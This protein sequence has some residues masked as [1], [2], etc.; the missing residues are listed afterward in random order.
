MPAEFE[1]VIDNLIK[2][3]PQAN[4]FIDDILIASKGTKIEHIVGGKDIEK[5]GCLQYRVKIAKMRICKN[6]VRMARISNWGKWYHAI[7]K[8]NTS[9]R[10]LA[11]PQNL[12][13][14]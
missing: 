6:G 13:N 14:S 9:K 12:E 7:S 3:F 4:A 10:R 8:K 2:E 5:A 1:K 11:K